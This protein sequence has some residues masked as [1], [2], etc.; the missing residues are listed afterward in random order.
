MDSEKLVAQLLNDIKAIHPPAIDLLFSQ[1]PDYCIERFIID[2]FTG[3]SFILV[4]MG[5]DHPHFGYEDSKMF[6]LIDNYP[7]RED[8]ILSDKELVHFLR[9]L[10]QREQ[11][12]V[13][14]RKDGW[15][16]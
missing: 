9:R 1:L 11:V 4:S 10:K 2:F 3:T 16:V 7:Y 15:N 5:T 14:Q 6:E 12:K 13:Y 8:Y